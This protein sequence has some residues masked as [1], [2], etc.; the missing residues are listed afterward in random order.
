MRR[1]GSGTRAHLCLPRD[2]ELLRRESTR[3]CL[4]PARSTLR[5]FAGSH[6]TFAV[7]LRCQGMAPNAQRIVALLERSLTESDPVKALTTVMELRSELDG[8]EHVHVARGL[9]A[10]LSYAE[11]ARPL[12][13]SR[14]AAHRRYRKL[15]TAPPQRPTLAPEARAALIRARREATRHGSI[16]VDSTHLLLALAEQ[17]GVDVANA[18]RSLAPPTMNAAVPSG[19]HPA[20]YARLTGGSG[21][22][23]VDHLVHAAL[24]EP[25]ARSLL[26]RLGIAGHQLLE[27]A[28]PTVPQ[29]DC[30]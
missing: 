14:Q 23:G 29:V 17:C 11:V 3:S 28:R 6:P 7:S 2:V 26:H 16:S 21:T 8:L 4:S 20:L 19:L 15:A 9:Q 13:I 12:G 30:A 5:S 1:P 24:E 10:G 25:E 22:L 27:L 18:R